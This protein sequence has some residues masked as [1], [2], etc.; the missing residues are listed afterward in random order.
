MAARHALQAV[1]SMSERRLQA[2]E[3]EHLRQGEC[4]HGEI[5]ALSANGE[6]ADD[7]AEESGTGHADD[8]TNFRCDTPFLHGIGGEIGG[9]A[10]ECRMAEGKQ[11]G[12]T[13]QQIEGAGKER[14]AEKLH[15]E[16]RINEHRRGDENGKPGQNEHRLDGCCRRRYFRPRHCA[17]CRAMGG[18]GHIRR[19][20]RRVR[21]GG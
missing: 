4:D 9:A 7:K 11:P 21:R 13:D 12:I 5:D 10:K 2:E 1:L 17:G 18:F 3:I 8:Q 14:K 6:K 15:Q 16:D 20:F 19:P